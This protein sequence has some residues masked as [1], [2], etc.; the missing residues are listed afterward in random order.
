MKMEAQ[1]QALRRAPPLD[2]VWLC[3]HAYKMTIAGQEEVTQ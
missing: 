1:K 2:I 3:N